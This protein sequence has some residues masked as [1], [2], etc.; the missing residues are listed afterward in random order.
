MSYLASPF[1]LLLLLTGLGLSAVAQYTEPNY[2]P[3][4][5]SLFP[6]LAGL[7]SRARLRLFGLTMVVLFV[8]KLLGVIAAL[9]TAEL[10]TRMRRCRRPDQEPDR[11]NRC[12]R[13]CCHQS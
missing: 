9:W 1:W 5:F 12:F 11:R 6:G 4:G 7:R 3:D 10:A 2:F 8:P 13:L